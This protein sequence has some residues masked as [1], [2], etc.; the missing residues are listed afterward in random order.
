[1]IHQACEADIPRVW[2]TSGSGKLIDAIHG[3][4]GKDSLFPEECIM[5]TVTALWLFDSPV[6]RF[7]CFGPKSE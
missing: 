7:R 4:S 6:V 1:M 3:V 5:S 2:R